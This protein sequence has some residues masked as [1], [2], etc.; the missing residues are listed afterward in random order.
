MYPITISHGGGQDLG[1]PFVKGVFQILKSL[2]PAYPHNHR[3]RVVGMRPLSPS[4][5]GQ[6][7]L[8]GTLPMLRACGLVRFRRGGRTLS[9][10][11]FCGQPGQR[12]R[13][14]GLEWILRGTPAVNKKKNGVEF[15]LNIHNQT[16]YPSTLIWPA[17]EKRGG[18]SAAPPLS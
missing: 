16:H 14:R 8:G 2:P 13:I 15:P 11:L 12:A 17:A 5:W 10:P 3:A 7:A 9:P 1:V 18:Q 6:G 4:T